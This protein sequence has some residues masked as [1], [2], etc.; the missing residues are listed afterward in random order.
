MSYLPR[1]YGQG[2]FTYIKIL[3]LFIG[4]SDRELHIIKYTCIFNK[5]FASDIVSQQY[6][7]YCIVLSIA[8]TILGFRTK[9]IININVFT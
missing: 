2:T 7:Y 6:C 9:L 5:P 8:T 4:N 1:E 3:K